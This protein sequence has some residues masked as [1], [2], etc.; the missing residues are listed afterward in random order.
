MVHMQIW[1][2]RQVEQIQAT[3]LCRRRFCY[4][5]H[6]G[7]MTTSNVDNNRNITNFLKAFWRP[8]IE[9]KVSCVFAAWDVQL[10]ST[11]SIS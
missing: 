8:G 1:T 3:R 10:S 9:R 5:A 7:Q 11:S 2:H 4:I 6:D